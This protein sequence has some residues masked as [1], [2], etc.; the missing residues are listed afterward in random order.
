MEGLE[1]S[2]PTEAIHSRQ[3]AKGLFGLFFERLERSDP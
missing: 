1:Q 3:R 2:G